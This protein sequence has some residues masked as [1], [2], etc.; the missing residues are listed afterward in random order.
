MKSEHHVEKK[1]IITIDGPAGSGKSTIARA[2]AERMGF[3]FLDTGAMYR[4]V[5]LGATDAGLKPIPD[6]RL[7]AYLDS[8]ELGIRSSAGIME[9]ILNGRNV[10]KDIRRPDMG[11]L[12][13]DF[14]RLEPVRRFC[15]RKQRD[16][17]EQG[18]I[19]AE[20]RDMG[21]V[22]FPDARWK[23]FLTASLEERARRRWLE[24][25]NEKTGLPSLDQVREWMKSRDRQDSERKLAPLKPA[26][27][28]WIID[29]TGMSVEGVIETITSRIKK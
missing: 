21:T 29:T 23:F 13:S 26:D 14:S 12:A 16:F 7:S 24:E 5:A 9:V 15:S 20:G 17:G 18:R 28:A 8:L 11:K 4:A 22:V 10:T 19:V 25:Q 3:T 2:V 27:D 1:K 6:E